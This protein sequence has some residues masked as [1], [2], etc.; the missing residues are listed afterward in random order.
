[1]PFQATSYATVAALYPAAE[2]AAIAGHVPGGWGVVEF[3]MS[4]VVPGAGVLA[5][6]TIFRAVYYL[7]P[8]AVGIGVFLANEAQ[9][10]TTSPAPEVRT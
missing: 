9:A 7:V 10:G 6:L 8:L 2:F 4:S 3:V 5:G 1:M